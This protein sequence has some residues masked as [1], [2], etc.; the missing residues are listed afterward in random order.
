MN[1]ASQIEV[2]EEA[3]RQAMLAS[4]IE[5]LDVLISPNLIFIT[6]FGS[7]ITKKEDLEIHRSGVLKFHS[8]EPSEMEIIVLDKAAYVSVKM[9]LAGI[10]N[11]TPFQDVIRFSRVWKLI[12][13]GIWQVIAGQATTVQS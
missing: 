12:S 8:I 2:A 10:F 4:D 9:R 7:V 3:L 1:E 13:S 6:H 11:G 5:S